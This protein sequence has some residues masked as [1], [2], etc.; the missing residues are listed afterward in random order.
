MKKIAKVVGEG[1][2]ARWK[3]RYGVLVDEIFVEEEER[4]IFKMVFQIFDWKRTSANPTNTEIEGALGI[5]VA[6]IEYALYNV[7]NIG[8]REGED[9]IHLNNNLPRNGIHMH[10]AIYAEL[11][12]YERESMRR[13]EERLKMRKKRYT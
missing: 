1:A 8:D 5:G 9:E 4:H 3:Q 10:P 6:E 11:M 13:I 2:Y 12:G 7:L